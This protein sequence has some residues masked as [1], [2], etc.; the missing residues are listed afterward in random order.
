LVDPKNKQSGQEAIVSG[1]LR[2]AKWCILVPKEEAVKD[3]TNS[4]VGAH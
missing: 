2:N 4:L 3:P 1:F